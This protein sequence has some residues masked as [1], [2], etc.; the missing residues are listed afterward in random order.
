LNQNA[1]P[2]SPGMGGRFDPDFTLAVGRNRPGVPHI[3]FRSCGEPGCLAAL[4]AA[5]PW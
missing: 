5:S 4:F 1:R 2:V 3:A